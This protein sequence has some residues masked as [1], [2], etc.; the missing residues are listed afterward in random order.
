[1][2]HNPLQILTGERHRSKVTTED[3][4]A[5][6][7]A[8]TTASAIVPSA[9]FFDIPGGDILSSPQPLRPSCLRSNPRADLTG[10]FRRLYFIGV[11]TMFLQRLH[12]LGSGKT[13]LQ[14]KFSK[15]L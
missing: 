4:A 11:S 13:D 5:K 8:I 6:F 7:A 10:V 1:M 3:I 2:A 9:R 12:S 15:N 14:L